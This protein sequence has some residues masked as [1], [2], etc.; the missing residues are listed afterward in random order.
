MALIHLEH[1]QIVSQ[2]AFA[3]SISEEAKLC[4]QNERLNENL[5]NVN[6]IN[7]IEISSV[8]V[9]AS[10]GQDVCQEESTTAIS[11]ISLALILGLSIPLLIGIIIIIVYKVKKGN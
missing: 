9:E 6:E 4:E 7:G 11:E 3:D 8:S 1:T 10:N 5:N 2:V